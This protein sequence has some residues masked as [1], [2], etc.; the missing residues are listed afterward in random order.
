[1]LRKLKDFLNKAFKVNGDEEGERKEEKVEN[2][3]QF[4]WFKLP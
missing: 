2:P 4:V 1:M 3:S